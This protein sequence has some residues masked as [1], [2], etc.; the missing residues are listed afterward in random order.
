MKGLFKRDMVFTILVLILIGL[1]AYYYVVPDAIRS[2]QALTFAIIHTL[3]GFNENVEVQSAEAIWGIQLHLSLI[4]MIFI[5]IST[6][7]IWRLYDLNAEKV[8]LNKEK[9][10]ELGL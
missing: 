5:L 10:A 6:L 8:K 3:T 4:P 1:N 9:L 7:T 2:N